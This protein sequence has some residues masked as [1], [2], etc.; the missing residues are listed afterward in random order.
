METKVNAQSAYYQLQGKGSSIIDLNVIAAWY[1]PD[2]TE[3]GMQTIHLEFENG[4][5][6]DEH[7]CATINYDEAEIIA[8]SLLEMVKIGR[9]HLL[10]L[11][12]EENL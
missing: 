7:I 10:K 11:E 4:K 2:T 6:E 12:K 3:E 1:P 8:I 5:D 9:R